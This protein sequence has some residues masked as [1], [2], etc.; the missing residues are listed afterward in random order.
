MDGNDNLNGF[1]ADQYHAINVKKIEKMLKDH[2]DTEQSIW[3]K[4][5]ESNL[6]GVTTVLLSMLYSFSVYKE[7]V[8]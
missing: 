2:S 3:F 4:S 7:N 1:V 8:V 6:Q 5:E